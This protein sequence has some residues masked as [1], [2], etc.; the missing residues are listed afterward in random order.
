MA[1]GDQQPQQQ[2]QQ[3]SQEQPQTSGILQ[4]IGAI[5][6][7]IFNDVKNWIASLVGD[8]GQDQNPPA[9]PPEK[10]LVPGNKSQPDGDALDLEMMS[11]LRG[12]E[13]IDGN[14]ADTEATVGYI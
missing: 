8:N 6:V 14:I 5:A 12:K 13:V 7:R 1:D 3:Q 4:D 9:P 10:P 2:D 11:P